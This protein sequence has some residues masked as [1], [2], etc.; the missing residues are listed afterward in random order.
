M[1]G[2][3]YILQKNNLIAFFWQHTLLLVSLFIMTL[4]VVLCVRSNLGSSVISSLPLAFTLAGDAGM[5]PRLSLGMYTNVLNVFLV[6]SQLLIL[7]RLFP[8]LQLLQLVLSVVFG[9]LIDL[10]MALTEGLVCTTIMQQSICQFAGCTVMG[11]G[12]A[13]EVRCDSVTMAGEGVP[14]ALSKKHGIPFAKAKIGVDITLV[15][16][17]ITACFLFFGT[18]MWNVIGPGTL[19]AMFYVGLAVKFFGSHIGWFDRLLHYR[20]GFRRYLYGLA[21]I[22]YGGE[23]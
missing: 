20:P 8:P 10:N 12:I 7:R 11:L 6:L 23:K 22:L 16:L 3:Q 19:F 18:W 5:T 21:R 1:K 15:V 2:T 9:A 13:L 4:G 14:V 17:A